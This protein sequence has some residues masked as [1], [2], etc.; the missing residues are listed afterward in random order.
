MKNKFKFIFKY[1][2]IIFLTLV[3]VNPVMV[4]AQTKST[5]I[6]RP[7][8]SGVDSSIK[9]Y[10]C[11][12][13]ESGTNGHALENCVNKM[14]RFG[15]AVGA[16][17]LVF[18]L[19]YAGYLYMTGGE[20]SK[21]SAKGV[22]Q[23]A[24]IGMALLL[25]SYLLL[26]FINP[27]LVLFKPIQPPIFNA[28]NLPNCE[29]VGFQ[30]DCVVLDSGGS[31]GGKTTII[32]ECS[33]GLVNVST[34]GIKSFRGDMKICKPFGE[35]LAQAYKNRAGIDWGITATIDPGHNSGCHD[36]KDSRAG[37]CADIAVSGNPASA[38]I[39]EKVC[40]Q[41][42]SVGLTSIGNE[43]NVSTS[44]C[45]RAVDKTQPPYD[46]SSPE[47]SLHVNYTVGGSS[48]SGGDKETTVNQNCATDSRVPGLCKNPLSGDSAWPKEDWSNT[49]PGLRKAYDQWVK[50]YKQNIPLYQIYRSPAYAAHLRSVWEASQ[51]VLKTKYGN[52]SSVKTFDP[53]GTCAGRTSS[54]MTQAIFSKLTPNQITILRS[55]MS[56]HGFST[57]TTSTTCSS[58]HDKGIGLDVSRNWGPLNSDI[59]RLEQTAVQAGLCHNVKDDEPHFALKSKVGNANCYWAGGAP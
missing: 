24:L 40:A 19:V 35:K 11:V 32:P 49:D 48:N 9:S 2:Q 41:M 39:W 31:G 3:L 12:P 17:A 29:E 51:F 25:G 54:F 46:K 58:D 7:T 59:K 16:I 23:N 6:D 57:A 20:S 22:L 8:Y 55:E 10:L 53:A 15:V 13:D 14:Y 52:D 30:T 21:A 34:L 44:S 42:K 50:L 43:S 5:T 56:Q 4:V 45:G 26:S 27:S 28:A 33:E 36:A 1:F 38:D 37:N 47:P 18:F